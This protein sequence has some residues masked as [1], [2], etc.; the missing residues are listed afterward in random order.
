MKPTLKLLFVGLLVAC[1]MSIPKP[2][3]AGNT[4]YSC[5]SGM[6]TCLSAAQQWMNECIGNCPHQGTDE[7][8]CY[9]DD[10]WTYSLE[11]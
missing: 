7:Q 11:S 10:S 5:T 8:I 9:P 4:C 1:V 2:V 6:G 3:R